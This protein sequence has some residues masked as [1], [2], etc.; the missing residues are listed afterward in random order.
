[1]DVIIRKFISCQRGA[2]LVEMALLM[3]LIV[4]VALVAVQFA[5]ESNSELWSEIGD[6]F[7]QN[8]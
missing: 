6:G 5:G 2:G 7:T 1:M 4:L 3:V 8:P